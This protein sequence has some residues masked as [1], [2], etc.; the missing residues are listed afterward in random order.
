VVI[1]FVRALVGMRVAVRMEVR[2]RGVARSV[3]GLGWL[4]IL[5]RHD[6]A[7]EAVIAIQAAV[8]VQNLVVDQVANNGA[9][10]AT[11]GTTS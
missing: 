9:G 8:V 2:M 3:R 7:T 10:R 11:S 5:S 1:L 6:G 4:S